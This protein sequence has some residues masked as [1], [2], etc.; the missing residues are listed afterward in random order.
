V[1]VLLY[2]ARFV[3]DAGSATS[4]EVRYYEGEGS[5]DALRREVL[6]ASLNHLVDTSPRSA[7]GIVRT[8]LGDRE[9]PRLSKVIEVQRLVDGEWVDV[10]YQVVTPNVILDGHGGGAEEGQ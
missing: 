2:R 3:R 6:E 4:G 7:A 8:W 1:S 10:S 5:L 9:F